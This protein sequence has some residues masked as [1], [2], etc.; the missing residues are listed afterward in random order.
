MIRAVRKYRNPGFDGD[1]LYFRS[2]SVLGRDFSLPGWWEDPFLGFQ[3]LCRGRFEGH[4]VGRGHNDVIALPVVA[5]VV[6]RRFY[7]GD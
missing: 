3:E 2:F 7:K 1:I 6:R 4:V 5:D